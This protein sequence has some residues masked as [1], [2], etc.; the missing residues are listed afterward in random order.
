MENIA[1]LRKLNIAHPYM[2]QVPLR[3]SAGERDSAIYI[4]AIGSGLRSQFCTWCRS[5]IATCLWGSRSVEEGGLSVGCPPR[6][7]FHENPH[8]PVHAPGPTQVDHRHW[9]CGLERRRKDSWTGPSILWCY[10]LDNWD[11]RN[12]NFPFGHTNTKQ[13]RHFDIVHQQNSAGR[14][15]FTSSFLLRDARPRLQHCSW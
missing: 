15:G 4:S 9:L 6:Q 5:P 14:S 3:G 2:T 7:P 8:L 10:E 12:S 13:R 11:H 1:S